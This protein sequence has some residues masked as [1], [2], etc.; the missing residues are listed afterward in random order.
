MKDK[1]EVLMEV[2]RLQAVKDELSNEV[3]NLHAL[4]EQERSKV[5]AL[6][7]EPKSKDK[8]CTGRN[9]FFVVEFVAQARIFKGLCNTA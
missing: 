3:S 5:R 1:A 2:E 7:A 6:T 4:L 8:V 9:F